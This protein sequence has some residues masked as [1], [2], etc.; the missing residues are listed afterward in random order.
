[1]T[2]RVLVVEDSPTQ[3]E[4]LRTALASGGYQVTIAQNGEEALEQFGSAPPDVVVSDV[5]MPGVVDGYELCRRIKRSARRDVPVMLLTSLSDPMD[6]IRGL[7][8]GADNFLTKPYDPS[9]LLDRLGVLLATRKT[10]SAGRVQAGVS[11]YFM[12]REFR[13]TSEREQILDLLITTFE[14]A[15]RQNRELRA[16]ERELTVAKE[17]LARYAGT[18]QEQ[19][20]DIIDNSP[21]VVSVKGLEGH[22][23]L[24]N[25]Q[26][27][28]VFGVG[29]REAIG[30][31]DE[32]L[33]TAALAEA[34]R[35]HDR[36]VLDTGEVREFDMVVTHEGE[37]RTY[38]AVKFPLRGS[39]GDTY[40]VCGIFTDITERKRAEEALQAKARQQAAI[41]ELGHR[42]LTISD[43]SELMDEAV[44]LV[45][46]TLEV[47][48]ADVFELQTGGRTLVMRAGVGWEA[49]HVGRATV[50]AGSASQA[51]YTIS[52]GEPVIVPDQAAETRFHPTDLD[53]SGKIRGGVS[54]VIAGRPRPYGVLAAHTAGPRHVGPD[55]ATFLQ[56]IANVL[57]AA[58]ERDR[59]ERS[60]GQARR[61]EAVGSLAGGVAHDFNN[62]LTVIS[63]STEF[64]LQALPADSAVRHDITEVGRAAERAATLTH[65]LLAFSRR[66]VLQPVV[67]NV[68]DVVLE[69]ATMLRRLLSEDI[70]LQTKLGTGLGMVKADPG[71]LEQVIMNLVVNAR[72]AMP[73][74]G[75]LHI[76]TAMAELDEAYVEQHVGA[77]PGWHV[78]IGVTDTGVGMDR[79]T[80]AR[81]FEPF[82]TTKGAR[83][84]G[85]GL[86]TVYGIVKQS[87]GSIWVYSEPDHGTTFKVYF[88]AV[89]EAATPRV[90]GAAAVTGGSET[91][92]LVEDDDAIRRLVERMLESAGYQVIAARGGEEALDVADGHEGP[93]HL[94]LSD[95]VM[96]GMRGP[97]LAERLLARHP[98]VRVLFMS[99]YTDP[100]F[101]DHPLLS[102]GTSFL[103]K[104][105]STEELFRQ[106]REALGPGRPQP[107]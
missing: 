61:L 28:R 56:A 2:Q 71:Q 97:V 16:R 90:R 68:N 4:E 37:A 53:V 33:L 34:L 93:I 49:G 19:L 79:E 1:M 96:P 6:I 5:V 104:P 23:E 84:T 98:N 14:D 52:A 9:Q 30:R 54:V 70:D 31:T 69:T 59:A 60:L 36:D 20:Q 58:I 106:V 32:E 105:F 94:L 17:Q 40:A 35:A 47:E 51:G 64:A 73:R 57:A 50:V 27:E 13:I 81:V 65:Q 38:L 26:F 15:V 88:P 91:V 22:Y 66:Q 18:L 62:L 74:G 12:G 99:G 48:Y 3:A 103:N 78:M 67:L 92:L 8:A 89:D 45:A 39:K 55:D 76:E 77:R 107:S 83:G 82:F 75:K 46:E 24:V 100:G 7:E 21:A 63:A 86:A 10:R 95:L 44:T 102:R 41:A 85:L 72:D 29:R 43:L 87:G 25:V 80:Q 101:F 11:V 42:A